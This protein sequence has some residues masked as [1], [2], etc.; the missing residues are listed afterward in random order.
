MLV[1]VS[2][3]DRNAHSRCL[4]SL[5]LYCQDIAARAAWSRA[6][7]GIS[8]V[9]QKWLDCESLKPGGCVEWFAIVALAA[10]PDTEIT[11]D[12]LAARCLE[13]RKVMLTYQDREKCKELLRWAD[14]TL[15]IVLFCYVVAMPLIV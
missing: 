3:I 12:E 4:I 2:P 7:S 13:L 15:V 9:F 14:N 1:E 5:L 10:A 11:I 8:E 6:P